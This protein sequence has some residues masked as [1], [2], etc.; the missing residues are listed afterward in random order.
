MQA[1]SGVAI[2]LLRQSH[3]R[4]VGLVVADHLRSAA[5]KALSDSRTRTRL[6]ARLDNL[7]LRQVRLGAGPVHLGR[8][9]QPVM[10]LGAHLVY[11]LKFVFAFCCAI[12]NSRAGTVGTDNIVVPPVTTG[13]SNPPYQVFQEKDTSGATPVTLHYQSISFMP[14]YRGTSFEVRL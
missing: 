13:S 8:S 12:V 14:A 7:L 1:R 2:L 5:A 9:L 10:Y 6:A 3:R 4:L 11:I